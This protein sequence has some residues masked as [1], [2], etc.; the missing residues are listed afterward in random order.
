MAK[1]RKAISIVLSVAMLA[2]LFVFNG[3]AVG[4]NAAFTVTP[5]A[6]QIAEGETITVTVSAT[7]DYYAGPT[8]IPVYYDASLF[9]FVSDSV[10]TAEIFGA[11]AT[12]VM[13]YS[14]ASGNLTVTFSP[15][16]GG[17]AAAQKLNNTVLFTFLLT[18][19]AEGVSAIEL[20]A[21][22][23]KSEANQGGK[24]FCGMYPSS[25][26]NAYPT[27]VS[28]PF[29]LVNTEVTVGSPAT[30]ELQLS[31]YGTENGAAIVKTENYVDF[32][33]CVFGIDTPNGESII[34]YLTAT[35][36]QIEILPNEEGCDVGTG[37]IINLLDVDGNVLESYFFIL[38]G[39]V[40]GDGFTDS[41]DTGMIS[42]A[43][44]GLAE[45]AHDYCELAADFDG[46]GYYDSIDAGYVVEYE[47]GLYEASQADIAAEVRVNYGF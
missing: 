45:F 44:V 35:A 25:A 37:A 43:E 5:S 8:S 47:V 13:V 4:Q 11:N 42:E 3:F 12:D 30:P 36:G 32:A 1:W 46:N 26:V 16:Y 21:E 19:K 24:L 40:N 18:A 7:T 23:Q 17:G 33:G 31:D 22:D 20:K 6:T 38:F 14:S 28:Q 41:I 29:T 39:D 10:S 2:G 9:D 34:D 27:N 15:L